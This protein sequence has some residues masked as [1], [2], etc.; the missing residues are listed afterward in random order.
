LEAPNNGDR[1]YENMMMMTTAAVVAAGAV[2]QLL[3]GGYNFQVQ[4]K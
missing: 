3:A 1:N 2:R 4:R